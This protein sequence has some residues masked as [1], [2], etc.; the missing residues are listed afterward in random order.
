[1]RT[2]VLMEIHPADSVEWRLKQYSTLSVAA[3]PCLVSAKI[4]LGN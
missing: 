3:R 1:M 4:S 2:C